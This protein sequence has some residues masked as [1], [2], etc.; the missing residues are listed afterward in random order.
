MQGHPPGSARGGDQI[1]RRLTIARDG[2]EPLLAI[3][4][5]HDRGLFTWSSREPMGCP[6]G[7]EAP[8]ISKVMNRVVRLSG[9]SIGNLRL[10]T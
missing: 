7:R 9:L 6:C 5:S 4:H 1:C 2:N 8:T 3:R 10:L